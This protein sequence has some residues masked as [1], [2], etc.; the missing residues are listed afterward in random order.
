MQKWSVRFRTCISKVA[1]RTSISY[2][3][4]AVLKLTFSVLQYLVGSAQLCFLWRCHS[5]Y[6]SCQCFTD[7]V[8]STLLSNF[9]PI[10]WHLDIHV[11]VERMG[12]RRQFCFPEPARC[13]FVRFG[14]CKG[15]H[16]VDLGESFPIPMHI[17]LQNLA[18][19]QPRTSPLKFARSDRGT[20]RPGAQGPALQ[21]AQVWRQLRRQLVAKDTSE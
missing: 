15:V 13:L 17:F 2:L 9:V 7:S 6:V 5:V 19:I 3:Q 1:I 4:L 10:C 16:C 14:Q 21:P 12:I 18:S 11:R 20:A 8:V